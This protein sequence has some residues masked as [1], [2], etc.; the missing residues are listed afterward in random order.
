MN[1]APVRSIEPPILQ[2]LR[3]SHRDPQSVVSVPTGD[4]HRPV[5]QLPWSLIACRR[6]QSAAAVLQLVTAWSEKKRAATAEDPI[7]KKDEKVMQDRQGKA[8]DEGCS[9]VRAK[10]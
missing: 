9:I 6:V 10:R 4:R 3:Y 2:D 5:S 8:T 7:G 1:A